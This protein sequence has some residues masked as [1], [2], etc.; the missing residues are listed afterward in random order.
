LNFSTRN[1]AKRGPINPP[2]EKAVL[3]RMELVFPTYS[4]SEISG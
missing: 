3:K 4:S 1:P 2:I